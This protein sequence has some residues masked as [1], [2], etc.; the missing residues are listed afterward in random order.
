MLWGCL[1]VLELVAALIAI[2]VAIVMLA[3]GNSDGWWVLVVSVAFVVMVVVRAW[4]TRKVPEP[5]L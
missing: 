5:W 2:P 3:V 4:W 1:T